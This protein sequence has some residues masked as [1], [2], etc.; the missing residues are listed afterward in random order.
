MSN[1][2]FSL[3][4]YG[5][6]IKPNQVSLSELADLL[7]QIETG[8]CA[9]VEQNDPK[10]KREDIIIGLEQIAEGSMNL[11]FSSQLGAVVGVALSI[12]SLAIEKK[13]YDALPFEAIESVRHIKKF[14]ESKQCDVSI[15][16]QSDNEAIVTIHSTDDLQ[17]DQNLYIPGDTNLYGKL[18]RVGGAKPQIR[19]L[20][21]NGERI[22]CFCTEQFAK[23]L[24]KRL[25]Q[26]IG[27]T[28]TAHWLIGSMKIIYFRAFDILPYEETDIEI[29]FKELR[30]IAKVDLDVIGDADSYVAEMRGR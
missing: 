7:K 18:E 23:S 9:I 8:I 29:A 26:Y 27:V 2:Q 5:N 4:F 3:H 11:K 12:L 19:I 13:S 17:I 10:T 22:T 21:D 24:A 16:G 28:G 30:A 15:Y 25:Y 20:Q 14:V 1:P 6:N